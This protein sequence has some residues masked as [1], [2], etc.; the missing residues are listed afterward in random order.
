MAALVIN[1]R[2]DYWVSRLDLI[3]HFKDEAHPSLVS[4][5]IYHRMAKAST[6]VTL[7]GKLALQKDALSNRKY[8][9]LKSSERENIAVRRE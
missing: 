5:L 6:K 4:R 8:P 3:R 9:L 1:L 2:L 7:D